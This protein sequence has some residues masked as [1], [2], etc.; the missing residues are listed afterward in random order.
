ME[1]E[2]SSFFVKNG[3]HDGDGKGKQRK[4]FPII[5]IDCAL[6]NRALTEAL[7]ELQLQ[8]QDGSFNFRSVLK[9]L[10]PKIV[11]GLPKPTADHLYDIFFQAICM[12]SLEE[13]LYFLKSEK[14]PE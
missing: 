4:G 8:S 6:L 10:P 5:V 2:K 1:T 14:L 9:E 3:Y 12:D 11:D 13:V 7:A